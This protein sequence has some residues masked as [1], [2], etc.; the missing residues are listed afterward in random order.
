MECRRH[1][2]SVNSVT[3]S[4]FFWLSFSHSRL[5][6][7]K[8][9]HGTILAFDSVQKVD[10]SMRVLTDKWFKA[11]TG[12]SPFSCTNA[13][14]PQLVVPTHPMACVAFLKCHCKAK[15]NTV[16]LSKVR[17]LS[18]IGRFDDL[19]VTQRRPDGPGVGLAEPRLPNS[20]QVCSGE[21]GT[22][23]IPWSGWEV[24]AARVTCT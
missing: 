20:P 3:R 18:Y 2:P 4:P 11:Q 16:T 8:A 19:T 5:T 12:S 21:P 15:R 7:S 6:R 17:L 1:K 10:H 24:F 9:L 14:S 13:C 23:T 22:P